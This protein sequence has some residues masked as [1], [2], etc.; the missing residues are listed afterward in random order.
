MK[1]KLSPA[2]SALASDARTAHIT[3]QKQRGMTATLLDQMPP[4]QNCAAM[5]DYLIMLQSNMRSTCQ[6]S[7]AIAASSLIRDLVS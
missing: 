6:Y 3:H 1:L 4:R 7:H 2:I 5:K